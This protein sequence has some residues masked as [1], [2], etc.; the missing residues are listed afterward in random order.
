MRGHLIS[1]G[2][3]GA[4][5]TVTFDMVEPSPPPGEEAG[6]GEAAELPEFERAILGPEGQ[7]D[8]P[9]EPTTFDSNRVSFGTLGPFLRGPYSPS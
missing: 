3:L 9:G 5:L 6:V 8:W 7:E 2:L 1:L 4:F